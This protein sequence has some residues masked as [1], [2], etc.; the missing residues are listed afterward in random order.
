MLR[1]NLKILG[2]L[3]ADNLDDFREILSK[4]NT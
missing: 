4:L 2:V 1:D 3:Y